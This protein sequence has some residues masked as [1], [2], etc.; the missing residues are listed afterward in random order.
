MHMWVC[1]YVVGDG[2]EDVLLELMAEV[3]SRDEYEP[4]D[5]YLVQIV[6]FTEVTVETVG[7]IVG[8]VAGVVV[9]VVVVVAVVVAVM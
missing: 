1:V 5:D 4:F 3:Y 2:Q 9:V 8:V 7:V 6:I